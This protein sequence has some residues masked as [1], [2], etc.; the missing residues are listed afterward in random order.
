MIQW[1]V[2][3]DIEK[4]N[5][6]YLRKHKEEKRF[7]AVHICSVVNRDKEDRKAAIRNVIYV[8]AFFCSKSPAST[9]M[10]A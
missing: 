10:L 3:V 1:L 5:M 8:H 7:V 9:I 6:L 4:T 2:R